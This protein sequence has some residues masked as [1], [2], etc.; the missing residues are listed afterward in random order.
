AIF[1]EALESVE[2]F[3]RFAKEVRAPLLA[4][5]TEFG[6]SPALDLKTLG[7]LGYAMVLYP[8]TAFRIAMKAALDALSELHKS[9][10]QQAIL[11]KMLTRAELYDLLDY[12]GYEERD[13]KFFQ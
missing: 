2:E 4:N 6:K 9:G 3:A 5:M 13:R 7:D 1:P 12:Q 10:Q 11:P 8:L